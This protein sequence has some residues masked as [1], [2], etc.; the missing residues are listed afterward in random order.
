M[1]PLGLLSVASRSYSRLFLVYCS[2]ASARF[3]RV[4]CIA[5]LAPFAVANIAA[6]SAGSSVGLLRTVRSS[7]ETLEVV[8]TSVAIGQLALAIASGLPRTI[9][10]VVP[11]VQIPAP[12]F[13][14]AVVVLVAAFAPLVPSFP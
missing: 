11:I 3:D 7:T 9:L 6:L 5:A 13:L 12:W 14:P 10:L 8:G 2:F 4:G 1:L